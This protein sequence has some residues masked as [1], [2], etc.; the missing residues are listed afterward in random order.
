MLN[1]G[2]TRPLLTWDNNTNSTDARILSTKT[3]DEYIEVSHNPKYYYMI[4]LWYKT[5][6]ILTFM[7]RIRSLT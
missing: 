3:N 4:H 7:S 2:C 5:M 1:E 6:N